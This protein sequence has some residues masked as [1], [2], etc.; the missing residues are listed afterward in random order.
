MKGHMPTS[1]SHS[2]A[3][4]NGAQAP[5]GG[6]SQSV[7]R[8]AQG[9]LS[10][11]YVRS[12]SC[13]QIE[14]KPSLMALSSPA[15]P[16][17]DGKSDEQPAAHAPG[18]PADAS[19]AMTPAVAT[20][21]GQPASAALASS[22]LLATAP[23]TAAAPPERG[24]VAA[25]PPTAAQANGGA[26]ASPPAACSGFPEQQLEV[27]LHTGP[28]S[29]FVDGQAGSLLGASQPAP[30]PQVVSATAAPPVKVTGTGRPVR[31]SPK[32]KKASGALKGTKAVAVGSGQDS[33]R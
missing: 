28:K 15:A 13:Q 17:A 29:E 9:A 30:A 1:A 18:S 4:D 8:P 23:P 31:S 19:C 26:V 7:L 20:S 14:C 12:P 22:A 3:V 10:G 32:G 11:A 2:A 24:S 33:K 27:T 21:N 6:P 5:G 16:Q 25:K